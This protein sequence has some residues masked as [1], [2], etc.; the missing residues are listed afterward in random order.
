MHLNG[1]IGS[2]SHTIPIAMECIPVID[3]VT[4]T[5]LNRNTS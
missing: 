1:G 2:I 3:R 5:K 4:D